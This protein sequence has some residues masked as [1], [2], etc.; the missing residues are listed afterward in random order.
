METY[1]WS[2]GA[3]GKFLHADWRPTFPNGQSRPD[4]IT[5]R[6]NSTIKSPRGYGYRRHDRVY[7]LTSE[8]FKSPTRRIEADFARLWTGSRNAGLRCSDGARSSW[9][10]AL[11]IRGGLSRQ[12]FFSL[13]VSHIVNCWRGEADLRATSWNRCGAMWGIREGSSSPDKG[14]CWSCSTPA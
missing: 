5:R 14:P 13:T 1:R 12:R 6:H 9:P 3:I 4:G 2:R 7:R 10:V 8:H 11:S